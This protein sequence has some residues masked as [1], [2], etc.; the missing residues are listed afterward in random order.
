MT[1]PIARLVVA[2]RRAADYL[3][4]AGPD[5][6]L[7][8]ELL[9]ASDA[10]DTAPTSPLTAEEALAIADAAS[11]AWHEA[12]PFSSVGTLDAM[13]ARGTGRPADKAMVMAV[14]TESASRATARC[15]ARLREHA[16]TKYE[17]DGSNGVA[18][19]YHDG[20]IAGVLRVLADELENEQ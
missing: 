13:L 8:A 6:E 19:Q 11:K 5:D 1:T 9:A 2:A 17:S 15:V 18:L 10:V 7:A 20:D 3:D 12:N 14:A 4:A 16:A